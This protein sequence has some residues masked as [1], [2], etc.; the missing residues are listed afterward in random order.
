M[1]CRRH[2]QIEDLGVRLTT[3][4]QNELTVNS[5]SGAWK[6]AAWAA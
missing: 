4:K 1:A 6:E 5:L 2:E 3:G